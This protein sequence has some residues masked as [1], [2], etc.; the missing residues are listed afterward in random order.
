MPNKDMPTM[1]KKRIAGMPSGRILSS[2]DDGKDDISVISDGCV[3]LAQ[4]IRGQP[5]WKQ[6]LK[7]LVSIVTVV[8]VPIAVYQTWFTGGAAETAAPENIS[9]ADNQDNLCNKYP[10]TTP[11]AFR[12]QKMFESAEECCKRE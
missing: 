7:L 9:Y 4:C 1:D 5:R 2:G 6:V 8:A 11:A 10:L 3:T 12:N